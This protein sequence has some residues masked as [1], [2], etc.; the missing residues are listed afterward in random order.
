[1]GSSGLTDKGEAC[2]AITQ[3]DLLY[4]FKDNI[5]K[6]GIDKYVTPY[7][8]SSVKGS[9]QF[10][11]N[12]FDFIFIDADHKYKFVIEDMIHW[13]PK[14]K[15]GGIFSGH[16]WRVPNGVVRAVDEFYGG[17]NNYEV[18]HIIWWKVKDEQM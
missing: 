3:E 15:I 13:Y 2:H 14:L 6:F 10:E 16:D 8:M 1:M 17:R 7:Q 9:K 18:D 4:V 11:D 12:Y 5:T